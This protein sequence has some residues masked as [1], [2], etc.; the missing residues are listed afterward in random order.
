MTRLTKLIH[1]TVFASIAMATS[2]AF[3][4]TYHHIDNLA[5]KIQKKAGLLLAETSHYR[6]TPEYRYLL[7]DARSLR[8]VAG[9]LHTFAVR[10]GSIH[11][12]EA[13]VRQLDRLFRHTEQTF[14]RIEI[15]ASRGRGLITG[16][17]RH[18]KQLLNAM[19]DCIGLLQNDIRILKRAQIHHQVRRV[20][21]VV[22]PRPVYGHSQGNIYRN[23]HGHGNRY[24]AR[25]VYSG[26]GVQRR[27]CDNNPYP[28]AR[29]NYNRGGLSI[30]RGSLN[31]HVG[32]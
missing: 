6:H 8:S 23:G 5:L 29:Y 24:N 1:A 30:Q 19:E 9:H 27:G 31:F 2:G 14:D 20:P 26:A 22:N 11:H 28:S 18:V 13:D 12:L 21:V 15:Q 25:P 3:A 17:T 16:N 7:E 4:D 32:F 10:H